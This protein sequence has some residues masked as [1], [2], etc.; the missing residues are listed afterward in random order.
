MKA[1]ANSESRQAPTNAK[2]QARQQQHRRRDE[3]D[4]VIGK[5]FTAAMKRG[6][7]AAKPTAMHEEMVPQKDGGFVATIQRGFEGLFGAKPTS[8]EEVLRK[9]GP[10]FANEYEAVPG[11]EIDQRVHFFARRLPDDVA[12]CMKLFRSARG[13][14]QINDETVNMEQRF[15]QNAQGQTDK[16]IFVFWTTEEG[17]KS[18]P[19]PLG[20]YLSHTANIA[21]EVSKGCNA[22]NQVPE[23]ARMS[24]HEEIGTQLTDGS[25]DA[26][27]T[28]MEVASRQA[29]MREEAAME[30]TQKQHTKDATTEPE[31]PL[32]EEAKA[33]AVKVQD[34]TPSAEAPESSI[35]EDALSAIG[36]FKDVGILEQPRAPA[37]PPAA[38]PMTFPTPTT[39]RPCYNA[40]TGVL[41][42]SCGKSQA[43]TFYGASQAG[44]FYG[45]SQPAF[46]PSRP[47]ASQAGTFYGASQPGTFYGAS[48][49]VTTSTMPAAYSGVTSSS[50]TTSTMPAV[51]RQGLPMAGSMYAYGSAYAVPVR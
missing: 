5:G 14:Y 48:T 7:A 18:D 39:Q 44:T 47:G 6:V 50:V 2:E 11:D 40:P 28:A 21:F 45:T 9:R 16:E 13:E 29:K 42:P 20:L 3:S 1:P 35:I 33:H 49:T 24:F 31:E 23:A 41:T 37:P 27:F 26:R 15:R 36:L 32:P 34:Q 4:T 12:A 46:G 19:E 43:G 17:E 38:A 22:I 30:W 51:Q 25:A 10:V 8:K